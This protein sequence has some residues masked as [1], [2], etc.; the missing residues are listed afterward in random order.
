[1]RRVSLLGILLV[2]CISW[3][4]ADEA[5]LQFDQA[6]EL[7]RRADYKGAAAAYERILMNGY[8][9]AALYFNLGNACFK[10]QDVAAS[11]LNYERA[12]KLAPHDEDI[13]YNLR[14]ANLRIVDK[15]DP[16]P[17]LFFLEWWDDFVRL[18]SGDEW[19]IIAIVALWV[20]AAAG[21]AFYLSRAYILQRVLFFGSILLLLAAIISF[22]T[23]AQR[24]QEEDNRKSA[25]VFQQSV[26]VK[27]APDTQ[28]TDLF[29]LHEG[30]KV[31]L[32]DAVGSWH[33]IRLSDGKVGWLGREA[34]QII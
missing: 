27:S 23:L 25:I 2:V 32:L 16:V 34:F 29:V 13:A 3:S 21:A 24:V 12:L 33:K 30:V 15:V 26:T 28:S 18:F 20:A 4:A 6:N 10:Q 7:Y 31:E 19:A 5:S 9:S 22:T 14:L 8:E 17:R 1:M 11:I